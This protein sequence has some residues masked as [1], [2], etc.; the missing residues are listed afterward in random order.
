MIDEEVL[1]HER[2]VKR[3]VADLRDGR[4]MSIWF[5]ACDCYLK[6]PEAR[7]GCRLSKCDAGGVIIELH[8]GSLNA[9]SF[10]VRLMNWGSRGQSTSI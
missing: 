4:K 1:Y 10:D 6:I 8:T 9:Q 2:T 3:G 7:L 5:S